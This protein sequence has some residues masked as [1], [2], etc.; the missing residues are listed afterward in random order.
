MDLK[1][2]KTTLSHNLSGFLAGNSLPSCSIAFNHLQEE[3]LQH[4]WI[5]LFAVATK[6]SLD[7]CGC[8]LSCEI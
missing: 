4:A 3:K 8:G 7:Q 1:I 2:I 6:C 5:V